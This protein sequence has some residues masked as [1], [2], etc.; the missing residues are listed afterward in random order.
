[1]TSNTGTTAFLHRIRT[2][3]IAVIALTVLAI[4]GAY[5]VAARRVA[6]IPKVKV[7]TSVLK[8][9]GNY[10]LVGSDSRAF[11][12]DATDAAHFGSRETQG[13]QRS[14][15]IMVVHVDGERGTGFIV[16]FP[17]DLWVDI[18]GRGQAKLNAAFNDGPQRLIETLSENFDIPISHYL[19]VDFAGFRDMVDAIG[20][21]PIAFPYPARDAKTGLAVEQAGCQ[22][23]GG[24]QALAY[25][26]ARDFEQLKDGAWQADPTAD[27][28]RISRQ[29]YFLRT[30]ANEAVHVAQRRPWRAPKILDSSLGS[31]RRDPKFGLSAFRRLAYGLHGQGGN[32]ESITLPTKPQNIEGAAAL[33]VDE[34]RAASVLARLRSAA[35]KKKPPAPPAGVSPGDVHIGVQNGSGRTGVASSAL[36]SLRRAGFA[37]EPPATNADRS[38]YETTEVQYAR[39]TEGSEDKA[40]FVLA[41]LGGAGKIVGV[42]SIATGD[43]VTLVIGGDFA[44]ITSPARATPNRPSGGSTKAPGDPTAAST[45]P[46]TA[47]GSLPVVGCGG[48]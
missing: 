18:P 21:I 23:L 30:L 11:V 40:R 48:I 6:A 10:L 7:D 33:V 24:E 8:P 35:K 44:E 14:D 3:L 32:I 28:G 41:Y 29:Q 39:D 25:V 2:A 42:D 20:T 38:D 12:E 45:T 5:F 9:G 13:G 4:A 15:T 26:R 34:P 22:H 37:V 36:A 46:T 19:Q 43:D 1:V 16:S 17:R 27:L 47:P 31:L